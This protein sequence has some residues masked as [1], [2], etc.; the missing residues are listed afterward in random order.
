MIVSAVFVALGVWFIASGDS[1]G[2]LLAG[3]FGLCLVIAILEPRLHRPKVSFDFRL[4]ITDLEVACEHPKRKRESIRWDDVNRIWY[5]TTSEG[6]W[7]PD[8]WI[9][10][11]GEHGGCSL[12]TEAAGIEGLWG[13][14]ERRFPGFD[15][16]PVIRGGTSEAKH[17]CWERRRQSTG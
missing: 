3:F 11:E 6:P 7:I 9:L 12:P 15:F 10:F 5:L 2:W 8:E 17:L 1:F 13:E 14:L 4:L 16:G